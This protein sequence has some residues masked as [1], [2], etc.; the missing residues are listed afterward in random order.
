MDFKR[1]IR[2]PIIWVV[3]IFGIGLLV[4][5][6]A[7]SDGFVRIDTSAAQ[8]LISSGSVQSAKFVGDDQIDLTL[9]AGRT[10]SDGANVKSATKVMSYYVVSRGPSLVQALTTHQP[11]KGYTDEPPQQ[12]WFYGLLATIIPLVI[13]LGLFWFLMSQMQGGGSKVMQFG[14][15]KAKLANKDTPKVTVADVAGVDE[16]V[17]QLLEIKEFFSM[18]LPAAARPCWRGRSRARP[19]CPSTPSRVRTSSRC[20]SVSVPRGCAICS[21]RPRPTPPQSCSSMRSTP[22]AATVAPASAVVTTSVSRRS[23]SFW[24]RW[25]ASTSRPTSS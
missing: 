7:S 13:I 8:K 18:D 3:L 17:E 25:T 4:L 10:Y 22:S 2:T 16:A 14:K 23:T 19:A 24:S 15:S 9:K 20:S 21:N 5:T 1:I 12:N 11:P 6:L